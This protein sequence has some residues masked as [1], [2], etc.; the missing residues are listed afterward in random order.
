MEEIGQFAYIVSHDLRAPL[1]NMIGFSAELQDAIGAL[2]PFVER[3]L[4][5]LPPNERVDVENALLGDIPE[6]LHFKDS[7]ASRMSRLIE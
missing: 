2:R 3:F 5:E 1:T 4:P 6:A 7:A